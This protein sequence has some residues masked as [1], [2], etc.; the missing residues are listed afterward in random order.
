MSFTD[1]FLGLFRLNDDYDDYDDY[2]DD[3]DEDDFE[4]IPEK[5][6]A[7]KSSGAKSSGKSSR[8]SRR[9]DEEQEDDF[10][11]DEEADTGYKKS[12]SRKKASRSSKVVSM[13]GAVRQPQRSSNMEVCVIKPKTIDDS[14]EITDTLMEGKAVVLNL[15]GINID[16]SQRIID[17]A[18][19]S[20]YAMGGNLQ[21]VSN[22]IFLITPPS[23][24]ISGDFQELLNNN[25]DMTAFSAKKLY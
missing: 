3:Y 12:S 9:G 11:S 14:R 19:G 13:N 16:T 25:F 1:K 18:S 4:D 15:E 2:E 22:Y 7:A 20:C 6:S 21:K 10:L 5:K 17:F 24:E 23:V 8:G